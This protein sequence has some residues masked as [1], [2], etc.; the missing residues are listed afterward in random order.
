MCHE[1]WYFRTQGANASRARCAQGLQANE[2]RGGDAGTCEGARSLP[3]ESGTIES[4]ANSSRRRESAQIDGHRRLNRHDSFAFLFVHVPARIDAGHAFVVMV[5]NGTSA[6]G[7]REGACAIVAPSHPI[8]R[9]W[10]F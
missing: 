5:Q 1:R 7:L 9:G 10:V 3:K 4:A 8:L 6:G 2:C